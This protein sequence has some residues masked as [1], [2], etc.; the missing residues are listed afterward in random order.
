VSPG[1]RPCHGDGIVFEMKRRAGH[2][3]IMSHR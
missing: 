3:S 2:M 1:M